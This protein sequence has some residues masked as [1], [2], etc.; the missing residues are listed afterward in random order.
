MTEILVNYLSDPENK[1]DKIT[2]TGEDPFSFQIY[3]QVKPG[4]HSG[5]LDEFF[6]P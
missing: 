1:L 3:P 4:Q 6:T 2:W 5:P